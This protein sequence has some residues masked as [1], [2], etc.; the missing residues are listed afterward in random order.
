[1]PKGQYLASDLASGQ[2]TSTKL[3]LQAVELYGA[4]LNFSQCPLNTEH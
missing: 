4:K 1:M 3:A 2:L